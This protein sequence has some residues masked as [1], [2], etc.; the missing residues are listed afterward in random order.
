MVSFAW[1]IV[2]PAEG[3]WELGKILLLVFNLL[4]IVLNEVEIQ[5]VF[6][7]PRFED[8]FFKIQFKVGSTKMR[9]F[10]IKNMAA[11]IFRLNMNIREHISVNY[12][13][14]RSEQKTP[15]AKILRE[16]TQTNLFF[17]KSFNKLENKI[18]TSLQVNHGLLNVTVSQLRSSD[19]QW[20]FLVYVAYRVFGKKILLG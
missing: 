10:M 18:K 16:V 9:A 4:V 3:N 14:S 2:S 6:V 8:R 13:K 15:T 5:C 20:P 19:V 12:F 17:H 7:S 1:G 11:L